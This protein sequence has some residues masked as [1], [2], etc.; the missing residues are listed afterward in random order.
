M[1][2]DDPTMA[3]YY[4]TIIELY[5]TTLRIQYRLA[6]YGEPITGGGL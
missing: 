6:P 4:K 5:D 1:G 3:C 2:N